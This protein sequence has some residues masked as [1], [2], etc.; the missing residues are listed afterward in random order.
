M[1]IAVALFVLW[2]V[3]AAAF[4]SPQPDPERDILVTFAN[5]GA[6]VSSSATAPYRFRKRYAISATA[7]RHA[8]AV[9][10]EYGLETVDDWPIRALSVY[11]FVFRVP[12][13]RSRESVIELLQADSR[14]ESAQALQEFRTGTSQEIV[15]D[16]TYAGMQHGLE[17]LNVASAHA[18]STGSGVRIAVID[19]SA[20]VEHEDLHGRITSVRDF[21]ESVSAADLEH[22]TAIVSVIGASANNARGIVGV[23]PEAEIELLVACWRDADAEKTVCDSFSLAKALDAAA[24]DP[25]QVL[26]MSLVGPYD[27]LLGRLIDHVHRLGTVIV[28]ADGISPSPHENFPA[29][30]TSVIA[31]GVSGTEPDDFAVTHVSTSVSARL[32]AP[33]LRVM[34]ATPNDSYDFRSGASIAAAHVSGVIALLLSYEPAL[35]G[36]RIEALLQTSQSV[37]DPSSVDACR[38]LSL[39]DASVDC[40]EDGERSA[41]LSELVPGAQHEAGIGTAR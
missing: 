30:L 38:A 27:P 10:R 8:R 28:A 1:R 3:P 39:I 14:V 17:Q 16:D 9:A 34:V 20:D 32:F 12:E 31:V 35:G 21:T 33:G 24:D 4:A 36:D 18:A 11:C 25:A 19:G 13:D 23:A 26:N 15:Y 5:D 22:G 7:S 29:S 37:R 2:L 40:P 6:E 41:Y